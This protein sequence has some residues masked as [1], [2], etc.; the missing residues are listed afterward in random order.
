MEAGARLRQGLL[1]LWL[2][3]WHGQ[4]WRHPRLEWHLWNPVLTFCPFTPWQSH[5]PQPELEPE[6]S[7]CNT[8]AR[9]LAGASPEQSR[10]S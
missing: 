6:Q 4:G 7:P 8:K 3:V 5:F 1:P 10:N 9:L 2:A